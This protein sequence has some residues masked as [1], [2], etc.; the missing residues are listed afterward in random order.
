MPSIN[1]VRIMGHVGRE[2]EL[3]TTNNGTSVCNFSVATSSKFGEIE[4]TEWHDVTAWKGWAD[5]AAKTLT[6]GALV[7]VEGRIE[8]QEWEKD[9]EIRRKTVIQA[10]RVFFLRDAHGKGK[11]ERTAKDVAE[12]FDGE[13]LPF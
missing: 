6:K 1:E 12:T 3:R 13:E 7:Y 10:S 4:R 8:T 2:P 9:G 11:P 5:V